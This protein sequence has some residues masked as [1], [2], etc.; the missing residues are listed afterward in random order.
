MGSIEENFKNLSSSQLIARIKDEVKL[1]DKK[2]YVLIDEY[3]HFANKL[4]SE[5][6]ESFIKNIMSSVG[7]VRE[8]Y[9]QLKIASGEGVIERF[10]SQVFRQ[11]CWMSYRVD[12]ISQAI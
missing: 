11:S 4:A 1:I 3:D 8:F 6:R 12:L 10:L 9:E 2:L 7:F 5:G